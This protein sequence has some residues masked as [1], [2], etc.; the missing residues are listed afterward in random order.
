[1]IFL[2]IIFLNLICL[3]FGASQCPD[4]AQYFNKTNM[5]YTLEWI[6]KSWINASRLCEDMDGKLVSIENNGTNSF[7]SEWA[8]SSLGDGYFWVGYFYD[9][10]KKN[11]TWSDGSDNNYTNWGLGKFFYSKLL[12]SKSKSL[13]CDKN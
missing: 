3:D 2:I 11:W 10:E 12:Y 8:D 7:L 13:A 1:M 6:G 4:K 9:N 5:C